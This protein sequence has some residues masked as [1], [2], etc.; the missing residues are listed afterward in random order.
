MSAIVS[1]RRSRSGFTAVPNWRLEHSDSHVIH[2]GAWIASHRDAYL[3]DHVSRNEICRRTGVGRSTVDRVLEQ[4][5][6]EGVVEVAADGPRGALSIVFHEDSWMGGPQPSGPQ[7]S[8]DRT[9]AVRSGD[10]Y[11]STGEEQGERVGAD[12]PAPSSSP[13]MEEAFE[14]FWSRYPNINGR[15]RDKARVKARFAKLYGSDD[16]D[17]FKR[18]T[19]RWF[20]AWRDEEMRK[21][22]PAPL[23]WL[24]RESWRDDTTDAFVERSAEVKPDSPSRLGLIPWT[25]MSPEQQERFKG[26][27]G[28]DPEAAAS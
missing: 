20:T 25:D 10:S 1:G 14:R 27:P 9:T 19:Q 18:G 13:E 21:F 12:A 8:G 22:V 16:H 11:V 7:P 4:L 23:A 5:A 6:S 28:V 2:V 15:R 3:T 17:E 26:V 24:N